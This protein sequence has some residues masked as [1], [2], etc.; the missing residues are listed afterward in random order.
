MSNQGKDNKRGDHDPKPWSPTPEEFEKLTSWA[1]EIATI[2]Q[3]LYEE[4]REAWLPELLREPEDLGRLAPF[5]KQMFLRLFELEESF[6]AESQDA[7]QD[8]FR[9]PL[10]GLLQH[11]VRAKPMEKALIN[12]V[13]KQLGVSTMRELVGF[14]VAKDVDS[15]WR[16]LAIK[17][18]IMWGLTDLSNMSN[19]IKALLK[20]LNPGPEDAWGWDELQREWELS[21]HDR[22]QDVNCGCVAIAPIKDGQE[23]QYEN[24]PGPWHDDWALRF[25]VHL[26][27]TWDQIPTYLFLVRGTLPEAKRHLD[28]LLGADTPEI[29]SHDTA[30]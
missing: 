18:D 20:R 28:M 14:A 15:P 10:I 1:R 21:L 22:Q 26:D 19:S 5:M 12:F 6:A 8:V 27:D 7:P 25:A 2:P 9:F 3:V 30:T 16:E 11:Y 24:P 23:L 29:P 17:F 13:L 4:S